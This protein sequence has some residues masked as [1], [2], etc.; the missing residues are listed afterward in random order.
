MEHLRMNNQT[1]FITGNLGGILSGTS[2]R[3]LRAIIRLGV[4]PILGVFALCAAI[5]NVSTFAKMDLRQ[6]ITQSLLVLS[7]SDLVF[8]MVNGVAN[9]VAVL[10]WLGS[11]SIAGVSLIFLQQMCMLCVTYCV[12]ISLVVTTTIAVVRC[13]GVV[14]PL[15]FREVVTARRQLAAI[16]VFSCLAVVTPA[17]HQVSIIINGGRFRQSA[18]KLGRARNEKVFYFDTFRSTF[19]YTCLSTI[20]V[21][22]VF[23]FLALKKSSE[24]QAVALSSNR[25]QNTTREFVKKEVQIIKMI[26]MVL[27]IYVVCSIPYV[28]LSIMR[29]TL[30]EFSLSGRF[31]FEIDTLRMIVG[32]GLQLNVALNTFVYYSTNKRF[33]KIIN[34]NLCKLCRK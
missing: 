6:G 27:T 26:S 28:L 8:C 21:S 4:N 31:R 34:A 22:M 1:S 7:L 3:Y 25:K 24:F 15:R 17:Y 13:L 33:K 5:T 2:Y 11:D 29:Q 32:V 30:P 20:V 14:I 19:F 23:L 10:L 18:N 16:A 9:S 12:Y